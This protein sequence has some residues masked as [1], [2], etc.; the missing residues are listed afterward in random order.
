MTRDELLHTLQTLH[1]ELASAAN[2]DDE[3]RQMLQV[4]TADIQARL[5]RTGEPEGA[6]ASL[7]NRVRDTVRDSVVQFETQHPQL[8]VILEK[9]TDGLAKLGI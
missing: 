9:L 2:L 6:D 7:A 4:V 3:T 1:R 5:H 8:A